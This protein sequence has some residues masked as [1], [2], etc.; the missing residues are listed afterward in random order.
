MTPTQTTPPASP[1]SPVPTAGPTKEATNTA[2]RLWSITDGPR[3][4]EATAAMIDAGTK[5]PELLAVLEA[6]E[7]AV[8]VWRY[9]PANRA[10]VPNEMESMRRSMSDLSLSLASLRAYAWAAEEEQT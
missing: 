2:R 1:A 7:R 10:P 6:A 5:L 4:I 8:M 3:T 9:F